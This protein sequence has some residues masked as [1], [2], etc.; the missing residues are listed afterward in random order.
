MHEK[1][2]VLSDF[3]F[4]LNVSSSPVTVDVPT[5]L[6]VAKCVHIPLKHFPFDLIV[7]I[8]N[9]LYTTKFVCVHKVS[10]ISM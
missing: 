6:I 5:S 9:V 1:T 4:K 2:T 10:I 8:P 7:T 3:V